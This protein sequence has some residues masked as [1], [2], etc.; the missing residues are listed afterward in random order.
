MQHH[1]CFVLDLYG[2][3]YIKRSDLDAG[4]CVYLLLHHFDDIFLSFLIY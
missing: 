1:S 4:F 2:T 3:A